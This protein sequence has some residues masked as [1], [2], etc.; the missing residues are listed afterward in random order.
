MPINKNSLQSRINN[1]S[2]V[3]GVHQNILL[4]SFFF[5][6]FLKRLSKSGYVENFVFKGGFLL[7]MNLG[8][9]L[10]STQDI[11]FLVNR[12]ALDKNNIAVVINNILSKLSDSIL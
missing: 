10:R 7:S 2:N 12:I 3:T 11:D 6:A 5:D 9:N 1:L 8:I 4:K